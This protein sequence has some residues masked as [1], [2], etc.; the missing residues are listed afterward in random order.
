MA[1]TGSDQITITDIRDSI[2]CEI[3]SSN[4]TRSINVNFK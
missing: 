4:G 3:S 1:L 2:G